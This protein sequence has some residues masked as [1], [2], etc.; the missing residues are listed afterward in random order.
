MAVITGGGILNHITILVLCSLIKVADEILFS[1]HR[2]QT[3]SGLGTMMATALVQNGARVIIASRKEKQLK[4][5]SYNLF[6]A[7]TGFLMSCYSLFV[8]GGEIDQGRTW[9][10]RVVRLAY[11]FLP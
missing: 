11:L 4:E 8:G 3:G 2:S 10:M 1:G 5:V 9:L 7:C 6:L